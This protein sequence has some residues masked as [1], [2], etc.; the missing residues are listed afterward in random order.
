MTMVFICATAN[1]TPSPSLP[2][3]LHSSETPQNEP[4]QNE[5]DKNIDALKSI[6]DDKELQELTEPDEPLT[7]II[8][9]KTLA[10]Q[11]KSA[12]QETP[13]PQ[14]DLDILEPIIT[15]EPEPEP[16]PEPK[17]TRGSR[18][19]EPSF[20][21]KTYSMFFG[22]REFSKYLSIIR[23]VEEEV[24]LNGGLN[25]S[26]INIEDEL[27]DDDFAETEPTEEEPIIFP[28]FHL[29]SILYHTPQHWA[30]MVNGIILT[31]QKN[32][33]TKE[34]YVRSITPNHVQL[35]WKPQDYRVFA[36]V[37]N[38]KQTP[39]QFEGN[40]HFNAVKHREIKSW[41]DI[42]FDDEQGVIYFTLQPNQ[43]F[44]SEYVRIYEG[45]P[46]DILP[47]PPPPPPAEVPATDAPK[48]QPSTQD[49]PDFED[50]N[51]NLKENVGKL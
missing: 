9:Q 11:E 48:E 21:N 42:K 25:T 23:K 20:T 22:K 24:F 51:K 18:Q 26:I 19:F 34:L 33:P 32:D 14:Q 47:P 41:S 3:S 4:T 17:I 12:P 28:Y 40:S 27:L 15:P 35:A 37:S 1:A 39:E 49:L 30:V 45:N 43:L 50:I 10:P 6:F 29:I 36:A 46:K 13:A 5:E 8:K 16:E 44:F 38:N 2:A 7:P 31:T